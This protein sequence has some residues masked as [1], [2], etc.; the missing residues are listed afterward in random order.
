MTEERKLAVQNSRGAM[1]GINLG[2][3]I[4]AGFAAAILSQVS[5]IY[6]CSNI[7]AERVTCTL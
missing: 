1:F 2:S 6:L 7:N 5:R 4:I 3:G